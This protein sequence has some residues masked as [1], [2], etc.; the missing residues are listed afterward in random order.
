MVISEMCS[1]MFVVANT[2]GP[3]NGLSSTWTSQSSKENKLIIFFL[4]Q[5]SFIA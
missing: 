1:F 5:Q 3:Q 2:K 4:I